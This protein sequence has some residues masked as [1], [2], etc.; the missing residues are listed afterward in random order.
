MGWRGHSVITNNE[1]ISFAGVQLELEIITLTGISQ[2]LK[3]KY[4][5]FLSFVEYPHTVKDTM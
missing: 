3:D 4:P 5:C 2:T 1:I